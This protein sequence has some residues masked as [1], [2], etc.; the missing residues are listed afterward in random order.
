MP[1][2]MCQQIQGNLGIP[3]LPKA[4][5]TCQD[6]SFLDGFPVSSQ[7]GV[8]SCEGSGLSPG[9]QSLLS[10]S[11]LTHP[12]GRG[13]DFCPLIPPRRGRR[14]TGHSCC[15][16]GPSP[17]PLR[18]QHSP[19]TLAFPLRAAWALGA[20]WNR[21]PSPASQ[22]FM[23]ER[24][25]GAQALDVV[26]GILVTRAA[27]GFQPRTDTGRA[28]GVRVAGAPGT[29]PPQGPGRRK[30]PQDGQRLPVSAGPQTGLGSARVV[31]SESQDR[32]RPEGKLQRGLL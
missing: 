3:P 18:W 12:L 30:E 31:D 29:L 17:E 2:G 1:R 8:K 23:T 22:H 21:S 10:P 4:S 20:A 16:G 6:T 27:E 13:V 9:C 24:L 11:P 25:R 28:G 15:S 32:D 14:V 5:L 26:P 7:L 19:T